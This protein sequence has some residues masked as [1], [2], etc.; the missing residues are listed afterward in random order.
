MNLEDRLRLFAEQHH[1]I[2]NIDVC[3]GTLNPRRNIGNKYY[4]YLE[5]NFGLGADEV[6]VGRIVTPFDINEDALYIDM[7]EI[8]RM[9]VTE[10]GGGDIVADLENECYRMGILSGE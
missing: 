8:F 1:F 5:R 9:V 7:N 6:C 10:G 4:L 2:H 3:I